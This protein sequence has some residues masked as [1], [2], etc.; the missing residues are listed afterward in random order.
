MNGQ[1]D[2]LSQLPSSIPCAFFGKTVREN[3]RL[4]ILNFDGQPGLGGLVENKSGVVVEFF[5]SNERFQR[6]GCEL[7]CRSNS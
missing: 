4:E 3:S 5:T 7:S 2:N 6:L 1:L